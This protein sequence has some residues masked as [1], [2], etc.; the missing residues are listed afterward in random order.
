MLRHHYVHVW[1]VIFPVSSEAHRT[2]L[3]NRSCSM[4]RT[5]GSGPARKRGLDRRKY[6]RSTG[7]TPNN[8]SEV[9]WRFVIPRH[10]LIHNHCWISLRSVSSFIRRKPANVFH[11]VCVSLLCRGLLKRVLW[12][13]FW[14]EEV[15]I[16]DLYQQN[17]FNIWVII[18]HQQ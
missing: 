6:Q 14:T 8:W 10:Q 3:R 2:D 12:V 18:L 15:T 7:R 5:G 1:L 17:S 4:S 13:I 9:T 11:P 16:Q